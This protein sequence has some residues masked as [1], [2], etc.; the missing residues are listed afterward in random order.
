MGQGYFWE[1]SARMAH[2]SWQPTRAEHKAASVLRAAQLQELGAKH[3][4]GTGHSRNTLGREKGWELQGGCSG[5]QGAKAEGLQRLGWNWVRV[6]V[7]L[8]AVV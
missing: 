1:R 7:A 8:G 2:S 6:D 4:Q 5:H 3:R